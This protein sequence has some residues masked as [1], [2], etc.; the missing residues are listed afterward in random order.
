MRHAHLLNLLYQMKKETRVES[1]F[2]QQVKK[3]LRFGVLLLFELLLPS[4]STPEKAEYVPKYGETPATQF[5]KTEYVFA[6]HPLHNPERFF[7]TFQPL[8]NYINSRTDQFSIKL[9]SSKDYQSFETKLFSRKFHFALP[10]PYQSVLAT[11]KGYIIFGKMGDDEK[12]RG[13]IVARKADHISSVSE[14]EG[15]A[16]SFPSATALAAAMMPKYYMLQHGL[17]VEKDAVCKYV[18]SQESSIMNVFLK[19]TKAG[20]SWPPPW[21]MLTRQR[22]ELLNELEIVWQ[23]EPLIN[24][25]LIVRN[26]I[27]QKHLDILEEALFSLHL[28]EK[29]KIILKRM[30]LSKFEK[31]ENEKYIAIVNKFLEKYKAGFGKLPYDM[32]VNN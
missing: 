21:E 19:K 15:E 7:E 31:I 9:E 5:Q 1:F 17:N 24:N 3:N 14:L 25:G 11:A 23:T 18:G 28:N 16:I 6:V 12:F 20:C 10:N 4:C 29:G 8:V 2:S 22:P 27:P 30:E 26:D 32:E 13:I